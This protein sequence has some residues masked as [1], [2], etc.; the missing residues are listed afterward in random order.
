MHRPIF[1]VAAVFLNLF[2]GVDAPNASGAAA[3]EKLR[4]LAGEWEG[5]YEWS[6]AGRAG[7][8]MNATYSVAS[9]GSAVIE[10]LSTG[11]VPSMTSVYHMDGADLR[12]THYC[13]AGNQP[14]LKAERIDVAQGI[15]DFSF[16]DI[17]NLASPDAGHVR[18][19]E[20]RLLDADHMTL[21]FVFHSG[22]KQNRERIDLR[23]T[24]Q[25]TPSKA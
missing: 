16:I 23:R 12:M 5:P 1:A 24:S 10:I 4:A 14:R 20:I 6:G 8:I 17:T 7:G 21:T 13:A 11:G 15:M 19:V 2:A 18:R 3:F 22:E 9:N 25:K